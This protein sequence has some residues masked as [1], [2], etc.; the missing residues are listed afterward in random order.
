MSPS[1]RDF[2]RTMEKDRLATLNSYEILDTPPD[3]AFDRV[4]ALAGH[5]FKVPV[6]L[7]SLVDEDRIWFK[8]RFGLDTD[9]IPRTPGLCASAMFSE[10]A[11]VVK[12]AVK[13]P[14][15]LANPLVV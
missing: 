14:R 6:C 1:I 12:N 3:G 10:K 15:T 13:D 4:T 2:E 11:Y 5:F 7:V 8:S 9:Q